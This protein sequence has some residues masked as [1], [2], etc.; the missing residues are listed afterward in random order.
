MV[1]YRN[2]RGM[3]Q[4]GKIQSENHSLV[5]RQA[6]GRV[7]WDGMARKRGAHEYGRQGKHGSRRQCH[8]T[9]CLGCVGLDL[10]YLVKTA[11]KRVCL[12]VGRDG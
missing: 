11:E 9:V 6:L 3:L 1:C 8:T 5:G 7:A 4:Y 2:G 12:A 10:H